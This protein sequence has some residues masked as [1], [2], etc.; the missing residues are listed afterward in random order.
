MT[1][2]HAGIT[3]HALAQAARRWNINPG[4]A[5]RAIRT[6]IRHGI[7]RAEPDRN[8]IVITLA[9]PSGYNRAVIITDG[10]VVTA[11]LK[12]TGPAHARHKERARQR[13]GHPHE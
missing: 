11:I 1:R 2:P 6:V 12:R 4:H 7:I 10:C 8:R 3:H 13:K 9:R 5:E